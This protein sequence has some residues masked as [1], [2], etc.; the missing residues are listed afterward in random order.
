MRA[1]ALRLTILILPLLTG[2]GIAKQHT[3][4]LPSRSSSAAEQNP[5]QVGLQPPNQFQS[6]HSPLIYSADQSFNTAFQGSALCP[7]LS[8]DHNTRS[9]L[10][11]LKVST[12]VPANTQLCLVPFVYDAAAPESCFAINGQSDIRLSTNQ[13]TSI[14]VVP[15]TYLQAYKDFLLTPGA[16][17]PARLLFS[18]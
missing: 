4:S 8:D 12:L 3:S 16:L 17:P 11:R 14:V 5:V 9:N 13:Y 7:G 2:C 10:V 18:L 1:L 6:C 15:A